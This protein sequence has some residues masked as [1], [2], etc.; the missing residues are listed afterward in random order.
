MLENGVLLKQGAEARVFELPFLGKTA[1][2]KQRFHKAYRHPVLDKKLTSKR[3]I[4]E[5]RC[6][7]KCRKF[8]ID[9]PVVYFVDVENST[10]FMEKVEGRTVRE[11]L[12]SSGTEDAE[13]VSHYAQLIGKALAMM[14]GCDVIHGD[15]TT[16]NLFLRAETDSLV[17]IDFGLSSISQLPEDKAVDLYVLER[18]F[19]STH[20]NSETLFEEILAE[21]K[22]ASKGAQAILKKL[23]EVRLRGR[24]RS[25]LG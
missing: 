18:A 14:H 13:Q 3:V 23:D 4:Q 22:K 11:A 6:L 8:G 17:I 2:A 12:L 1:I 15:L 21:Y 16:S 5:A 20:P 19:L 7:L 10:I 24:K 9:T 25:M